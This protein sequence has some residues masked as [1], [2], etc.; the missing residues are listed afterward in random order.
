MGS[1][2]MTAYS[3]SVQDL[4]EFKAAMRRAREA[5]V[6]GR[7]KLEAETGIDQSTIYRI[8]TDATYDPSLSTVAKLIQGMGLTLSGFFTELE[9]ASNP[10]LPSKP[11]PLHNSSVVVGSLSN[12]RVGI[13]RAEPLESSESF[14]A[15]AVPALRPTPSNLQRSPQEV[16]HA[17]GDT[18]VGVAGQLAAAGAALLTASAGATT[19]APRRTVSRPGDAKPRRRRHR[20]GHR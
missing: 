11:T 8:E 12:G 10:I 2:G 6:G 13:V 1:V 7:A 5:T 14:D 16:A 9:A 4:A 3:E 17:L 15:V 19:G 18:L 20:A